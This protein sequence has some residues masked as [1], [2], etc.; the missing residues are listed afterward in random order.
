MQSRKAL[1]EL[2]KGLVLSTQREGRLHISVMRLYILSS[3]LS[4]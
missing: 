1:L 3:A 4:F 2:G